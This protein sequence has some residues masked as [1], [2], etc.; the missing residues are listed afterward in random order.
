MAYQDLHIR[1]AVNGILKLKKIKSL[2][3]WLMPEELLF[4]RNCV[5]GCLLELKVYVTCAKQKYLSKGS[6]QPVHYENMPIRI[7]RKVHLQKLKIFRL[8]T[9]IFHISAQNIDC[10]YSLDCLGKAVL[11]GTH[12]LCF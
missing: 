7:Y 6:D 9:D 4:Y 5:C 12:N 3:V 8:K 2:H 11:S 10:G 1:C